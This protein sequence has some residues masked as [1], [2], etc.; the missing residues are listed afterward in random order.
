YAIEGLIDDGVLHILAIF[1]KPDPLDGPFFEET[2]YVTPSRASA[3]QQRAITETVARAAA[4]I[5]LRHGPI[6]AEC[7]VNAHGVFVLEIAPRPI[8]GLC[9][10]AL[11]FAPI[12]N[13][14][15]IVNHQPSIP[16]E[17]LLLRH[18]LGDD[19]AGYRRAA[20]AAG[21]MMIPIPRRG[22]YRGVDGV[23][24]ARG[25]PNIVDVRITAK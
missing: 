7:R 2:I 22:I 1:D 24:A 8:G 23:D 3:D 5:G 6:H 20:D 13:Q 12:D 25:V 9:A 17:E 4:A 19:P 10:R 18:A 11:T 15:S 16:L 14:S 21:V